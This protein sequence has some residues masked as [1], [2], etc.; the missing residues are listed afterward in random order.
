MQW[1]QVFSATRGNVCLQ[2]WRVDIFTTLINVDL[3]FISLCTIFNLENFC[4]VSFH[5]S[6]L[7]IP[8][9]RSHD[10][11]YDSFARHGNCGKKHPYSRLMFSAWRAFIEHGFEWCKLKSSERQSFAQYVK[12]DFF[13][14]CCQ[15]SGKI[16]FFSKWNVRFMKFSPVRNR[17]SLSGLMICILQSCK[18]PCNPENRISR[19]FGD[20][21]KSWYNRNNVKKDNNESRRT[22]FQSNRGSSCDSR[23]LL[24]ASCF[25][26]FFSFFSFFE[27]L[28][29]LKV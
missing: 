20:L 3:Y 12:W 11:S 9:S 7:T 29:N 1:M 25:L 19:H 18:L 26:L 5:A 13:E 6:D 14:K 21:K 10:I 15:L 24:L 2:N 27:H 23:S 4:P 16:H 22:Q 17:V 8:H 28:S